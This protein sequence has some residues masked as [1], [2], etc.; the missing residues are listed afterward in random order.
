LEG[1]PV[2]LPD[3]GLSPREALRV[4]KACGRWGDITATS[5]LQ[6]G[7]PPSAFSRTNWSSSDKFSFVIQMIH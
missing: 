2:Q 3:T 5:A 1:H 6:K 7:H 4:W